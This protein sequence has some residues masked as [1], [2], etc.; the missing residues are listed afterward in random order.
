VTLAQLTD[1]ELIAEI[2]DRIRRYRLQQNLKQEDLARNAGI[3]PRT[4]R[5]REGGG[6]VRLSTMIAVLRALGRTDAVDA[7]LPH[8]RVSPMELL[9]AGGSERRR[10]RGRDRG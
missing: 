4:V 2:G 3:S 8:P 7:F 9:E 1:S 10:A 6:D 5:N